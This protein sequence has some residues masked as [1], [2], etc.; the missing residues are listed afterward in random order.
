MK[1][2]PNFIVFLLFM[3]LI[4]TNASSKDNFRKKGDIPKLVNKK[5]TTDNFTFSTLG[6]GFST[7]PYSFVDLSEIEED[8]LNDT[9]KSLKTKYKNVAFCFKGG[10]VHCAYWVKDST[11]KVGLVKFNGEILV[12]PVRGNIC[13]I[14]G[15]KIAVGETEYDNQENW[16]NNIEMGIKNINGIAIGHFCA[17][18][19]KIKSNDV[20]ATIPVGTYDDIMVTFKGTRP[21]F[22]VA[23]II[24][25]EM[26]WGVTKHDGRLYIPIEY[27]GIY[28]AE[29]K[30]VAKILTGVGGSKW[31]GSNDM[32]MEGVKL[33][34]EN[35]QAMAEQ[36]KMELAE[37]FNSL[38][39]TLIAASDVVSQIESTGDNG[40]VGGGDGSSLPTQYANWERRAKQNYE[41]LTN[42]GAS[43]K[44]KKGEIIGGTSGQGASPST[45]TQQK[46]YLR[47]AQREMKNIRKKAKKKGINIPQSEYENVTVKY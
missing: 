20:Y 1:I 41:S 43:F 29:T 4:G 40:T 38:G 3:A 9:E 25:N 36:R 12:P 46:K 18:V 32:D 30:K 10:D 6:F 2:N 17:V 23:K 42:L 21:D 27:K 11:D 47:E 35:K 39:E 7:K 5:S 33:M 37:I 24:N 15:D 44:D 13:Q 31:I 45:Y 28:K 14:W 22:F 8:K 34:V 19:D 16:L 26:R